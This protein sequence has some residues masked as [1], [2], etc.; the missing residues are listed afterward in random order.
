MDTEMARLRVFIILLSLL[1]C[2]RTRA[3]EIPVI[4]VTATIGESVILPCSI[5]HGKPMDLSGTRIYWQGSN[6]ARESEPKVAYVYNKGA[7]EIN[8]QNRL[9]RNRTSLFM[10]ELPFGNFSLK[11]T[12]VIAE[13]YQTEVDVLFQKNFE[14]GF[15]MICRIALNVTAR[16]QKPQVTI[17]CIEGAGLAKVLCG[18]QGGFP[19]GTVSWSIQNHTL[20]PHEIKTTHN[21]TSVQS[22][23]WVNI[24]KGQMVTCTVLNPTLQETVNTSVTAKE[25]EY[26][27]KD[28]GHPGSPGGVGSVAVVAAVCGVVAVAALLLINKTKRRFWGDSAEGFPKNIEHDCKIKG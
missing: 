15:E 6:K 18:S 8:R 14:L 25:C 2:Q 16:W 19:E 28:N 26:P 24:S 3:A 22:S 12:T 11:L 13:D 7:V 10:D 9:Y 20:H 21:G 27:G 4:S 17:S 1:G 23:L 5:G